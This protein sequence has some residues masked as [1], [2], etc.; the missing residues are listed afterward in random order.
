[1]STL[2][3]QAAI[4]LYQIPLAAKLFVSDYP[5]EPNGRAFIIRSASIAY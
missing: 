1:M 2:R 3:G 4:L 5:N